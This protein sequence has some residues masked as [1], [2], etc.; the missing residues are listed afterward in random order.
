MNQISGVVLTRSGSV[1]R[2]HTPGGEV[3]AVLRGKVK[4]DDD[5]RVVPGDIVDL[6][7]HE[8][9][10]AA[11]T[12]VHPRRT[13]LARRAAGGERVRRQQPIA[14]NVD[15]VMIVTSARDPEP[16]PRMVDRFLVIAE[17]NG[18]PAVVVVNKT[19][20]DAGGADA[21][22]R[23]LTP[24][25]Y[26]ILRSSVKSGAGLDALGEQLRGRETVLAGQSGVGKSS[27][28][29]ALEPALGR[30]VGEVSARWGKGR[31]TTTAAELLPLAFG[32]YVVDT[33][34]MREVG[35]WGL[36]PN[37]LAPCF[38]EF[39]PFLDQC[40]FDDCRHLVEPACAVRAAAAAGA[41][42][43]DRLAS[44]EKLYEEIN[45][46]SWSSAPRRER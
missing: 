45:V 15:Q 46:P 41:F 17:A 39:R 11:I 34:G 26:T 23:R 42:D 13:V 8:G 38:P 28:L 4:R 24:A 29:N 12:R 14:A 7:L 32:G 9:G 3:G 6:D 25:G 35:T 2:V 31:H 37:G 33:P 10:D 1:Y 27:L 18:L 30:R 20:L 44:Y 43:A 19:D 16:V 36:D 40:R 22:T 5:D 21:L